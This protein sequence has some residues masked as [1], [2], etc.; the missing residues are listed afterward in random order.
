M[1]DGR[2]TYIIEINGIK[3]SADAVD[4]LNKQLDALEKRINELNSKGISVKSSGGSSSKELNAEE[5]VLK[6]IWALG[7]KIEEQE[8]SRAKVLQNQKALLKEITNEV[9]AQ[10]AETRLANNE[11]ANTMNG[12]KAKLADIKMSMGNMDIGG[13]MFKKY[14]KEANEIT[15]KL[16][17]IEQS[18]GQFGRNV[19]NY[20]NGVAEGMQ[21]LTIKVGNSERTF[22]SAKQ[23]ARELG[24]ELKTMAVQGKQGT[25]E[26]E[27]LDKT[28]KQL[29]S[30]I[31]DTNKSSKF[32]DNLLDTMQG[33]TAISSIGVGFSQMFGID[34][35]EFNNTMQKFAALTLAM[36]GIEKVKLQLT[37][38]EGIGKVFNWI[39][40][41]F[42]K[43]GAK[44]N[45]WAKNAKE[46]IEEVLVK[47]SK[48][49]RDLES[50]GYTFEGKNSRGDYHWS[51]AGRTFFLDEGDI[52]KLKNANAMVK[53]TY[54]DVLQTIKGFER[55]TTVIKGIGV[56][57]NV[58]GKAIK[59][60]F[61][62]GIGMVFI[63]VVTK[64][65]DT[66]TDFVKSLDK[67]K[68]A[69]DKA[70]ES[71][72]AL[73]RQLQIRRDLLG[74][75]YLRKQI[76]DEEYLNSLYKEES[77]NIYQSIRA[78]EDRARAMQKNASNLLNWFSATQN[79][80]FSGKE[81]GSGK[82]VGVG[83][84]VTFL[85][86]DN[87]LNI[88][89]RNIEELEKAW[90]NCN[91]AIASN[92]DY[93]SKWGSGVG[94]W[95]SSVFV[96]VS[97]TEKAMRGL[98]NLR[99][100]D[101]VAQ[102]GEINRQ[103]NRGEISAEEFAKQI[104]KLRTEMNSNE[105]L[106]SVIANLD[107]YI[108]DEGVRTAVQNIINELYRLDDAFNMTSP[109][110]IHYWN[111]VR[112]EG[113]KEGWNKTKAQIDEEERYEIE[114]RAHTEEQ[115]GL[116]QKKY[117]EK[118][119]KAREQE[120]K[121]GAKDAKKSAKTMQD[122][123]NELIRL[124]IENMKDGLDK[125]LALIED[126]RR[127]AI[128]KTKEYGKLRGEA[129]VEINKKYDK[130]VLDRK[131]QW[132][133]DVLKIY[134]DLYARIEQVNRTTFEKEVSTAE[135]NVSRKEAENIRAAGYSAI[136]PSNYDN[137]K[138]LEAYYK[139]VLEIEKNALDKQTAIR[140]EALAKDEEY[141]IKEEN[142][143]YSRLVDE[144]GGEYI[145]QLRAGKLTQEKYD[146]LIEQE[147][148][149]HEA[150]LNA[151][152]KENESE[153]LQAT[154]DNLRNTQE[155]Y[156]RYFDNIINGVRSDM[157]KINEAASKP[158][159]VDKYGWDVINVG[160]TKE[161]YRAALIQYENLKNGIIEKQKEL[162][163]ALKANKISAEDFAIKKSELDDTLK[164]INQS[165]KEVKESQKMLV[166]DFVSSLM[167]YIQAVSQSFNQI[168]QA[169]WDAQ[170][171]AFDKE[172][173]NLDKQMQ[174][175]EERL[176]KQKELTEKYK[177]DVN[178]IEE[179]LSDARGDRRQHL[180]DQLNAQVAAQR[181]S[182]A[183]EK[184]IEKEKEAKQREI[185]ELDKKR[186]RAEYNRNVTQA[187]ANGAMAVVMAAVN[188]WPIPAIP[189]MALAASTTAAQIA[190]MKRS[191]PYAKGGV[192]SGPS[193]AN[194]GIPVGNTGIEVEGNEYVIR[195]RS[196]MP[197]VGVLDFIN[198]SER[199]LD[200]GD[201]EEFFA[202]NRK[203]ISSINRNIRFEQGGTLPIINNL[204]NANDRLIY[205][206]QAYANRPTV[207]EVK[208][209]L[210]KADNIKQVQVLAGL[211]G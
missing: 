67:T 5:R 136:T 85:S 104:A 157:S 14:A 137:T 118:R 15:K 74:S 17:E 86:Q 68:I 7:D 170:D 25:K 191:K 210:N 62:L 30:T 120:N 18:Y 61:S 142:L 190:I 11:Y 111:M 152:Q 121:K 52:A 51:K 73:N 145:Q 96:T 113:M 4:A 12:L 57:A 70:A 167:P 34:D 32:M 47:S 65:M 87:D 165:V 204:D 31:Q 45:D 172:Q 128:Q 184:K 103:F 33:F 75:Q 208:E 3:E 59:A 132:A 200:I 199:K 117:A 88:T 130:K 101:F 84:A 127:L 78:L 189:M 203:T 211:E 53:D 181:A 6:K 81:I 95:V 42:D 102:F 64:V 21:Q 26:Y 146:E 40:K 109:E 168:M 83:R 82:T 178:D 24:N 91:E 153:R 155:I 36:Q 22:T 38:D 108:P 66:V 19:G 141:S 135:R 149:A 123:E 27:E 201:F 194:G 1:A 151:I 192:L 139:K 28:V 37:N 60:M 144:N 177:D 207:V 44:I 35:S 110:Q 41:P 156:S 69:A 175:I 89:V 209:I 72:Q 143:R 49:N 55:I 80:E 119:R 2:K 140:E 48:L 169:V 180:I 93:L 116:L 148:L 46:K 43:A 166:A 183:E 161:N 206:M 185:D 195:K 10:A 9:K 79:T 112:I 187:I 196:T 182:W 8:D 71:M 23:A 179:E 138:D 171:A 174:K 100:S 98:G 13:D 20:A 198:K 99:L 134:E 56:A 164:D 202:K 158:P 197:N 131:R 205:A 94:D 39:S 160:A 193:H 122:A 125:E 97:D 105:I 92:K 77:N 133:F 124:R 186:K 16:K 126:E 76:N 54:R 58:A 29:N 90:N 150:R 163:E 176:N 63:E 115:V 173:E 159:V 154:E 147:K 106:N 162:E 129:I 114:Q 50:K 188:K 107:K